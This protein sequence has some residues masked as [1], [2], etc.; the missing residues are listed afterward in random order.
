ML[1]TSTRNFTSNFINAMAETQLKASYRS[2]EASKT[3]TSNLPYMRAGEEGNDV[4]VKTAYLSVLRSGIGQMQ[5]DVN[6]FLTRKMEEEKA[7]Q[8][9]TKDAGKAKEERE[10]EMYGEEDPENDG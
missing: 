1:F 10:E 9:G 6:A 5:S 4:K 8:S 7:S 3:F 2:S